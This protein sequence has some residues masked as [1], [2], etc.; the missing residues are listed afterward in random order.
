MT[1]QRSHYFHYDQPYISP[2]PSTFH[3][4]NTPRGFHVETTWKRSF[5][6]R[7]NVESTWCVCKDYHC[8][9]SLK[10]ITRLRL[11]LSH[12]RFLKFKHNFQDTLNPTCCCDTVKTT[13]HYLLHCPNFSNERVTL[14]SK[15]QSTDENI[16]SK[17][18]SKIFGVFW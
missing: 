13:I 10:L 9:D 14:F 4:T 8:P 16:L 3:P 17:D 1:A 2:S 11:G 18:D 15:L 12:L 5:P 6:R 7:F